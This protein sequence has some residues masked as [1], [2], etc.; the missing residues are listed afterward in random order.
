M[1]YNAPCLKL[2]EGQMNTKESYVVCHEIDRN[3]IVIYHSLHNQPQ[4]IEF[5][6]END[7]IE[8]LSAISEGY[9]KTDIKSV[10]A[11]TLLSDEEA[12]IA[13]SKKKL[14]YIDNSRNLINFLSIITSENCN[15]NCS[16]CIMGMNIQAAKK[17]KN[18]LM[19]WD[20]AQKGLDWY[21]TLP[22]IT[23]QYYINFSGG[24]P[25]INKQVVIQSIEYI[26]SRKYE[27]LGITQQK[28]KIRHN[29]SKGHDI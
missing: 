27:N 25:L 13:L 16:Y 20:I 12:R 15:L 14:K 22:R 23:N 21:F 9:V 4:Q 11:I 1:F 29:S 26:R 10:D 7:K 2:V 8:F 6:N 5:E 17:K 24:E 18:T 28:S 3:K 19:T